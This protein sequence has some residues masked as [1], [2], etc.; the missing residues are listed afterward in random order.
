MTVT[1][2][3]VTNLS[4]GG[5]RVEVVDIAKQHF[6]EIPDTVVE[7]LIEKGDVLHCAGGFTVEDPILAPYLGER[8]G[9]QDSSTWLCAQAAVDVWLF[10][11]FAVS[12]IVSVLKRVLTL[13]RNFRKCDLVLSWLWA[14]CVGTT[15]IQSWGCR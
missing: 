7:Q 8:I 14:A 2:V 9:T 11:R 10:F 3:V 6:R 4:A 15:Q 5:K 13:L 12:A 1:A